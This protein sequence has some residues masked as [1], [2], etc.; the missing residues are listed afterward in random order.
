MPREGFRALVAGMALPPAVNA[1]FLFRMFDTNA[2]GL[3]SAREF[4]LGF[5]V[6]SRGSMRDRLRYL[7]EM[8]DVDSSGTL[9]LDEL[10]YVFLM[11]CNLRRVAEIFASWSTTNGVLHDWLAGLG[12]AC[13]DEIASLRGAKERE[14]LALELTR[15]G[16]LEDMAGGRGLA[17]AAAPPISGGA[18][19]TSPPGM[20][21]DSSPF[22]IDHDAL[23]LEA[24]IGEGAH[25]AVWRGRWLMM[26]V[27]IKACLAE[28]AV[29]SSLRHPNL[30]LYMGCAVQ[31]H[32]PLC[33]VSELFPGGSLHTYLHGSVLDGSG[34]G[35]DADHEPLG[36]ARG[37]ARGLLYLHSRGILHCDLKS[38]NV[39][40]RGTHTVMDGEPYT[41][42]A[43]VFSF[44]VLLWEL[45]TRREPWK[46][47]RPVQILFAVGV[48]GARLPIPGD[49]PPP[50]A[51]LLRDCWAADPAA[52]PDFGHILRTLDAMDG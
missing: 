40:V 21:A 11:L 15:I 2:S 5:A 31:P 22:L 25:A 50:V 12:A 48:E 7:F 39:L 38:Q 34:R 1:D 6:L 29:L 14:L 37:I 19:D 9:S 20:A 18:A 4:L 13:G 47:L 3:V 33:I 45:H 16:F 10:P 52:R 41:A 36:F 49:L 23:S 42:A 26:P 30:L 46:G 51:A 44:G 27:A 43:D 28:V 17:S 24:P 8:Y 32:K 35:A